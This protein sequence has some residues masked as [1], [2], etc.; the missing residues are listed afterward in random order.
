M[1]NEEPRIS[2]VDNEDASRDF[3]SP[4]REEADT[5]ASDAP[6]MEV[7]QATGNQQPPAGEPQLAP[8]ATEIVP[9]QN[10]VAHLAGNVSVDDIRV[11]GANLVL[12]QADGTEIVIVNGALHVPTFLIGDVALP[13]QAVIA[14][15]EQNHVN[16]AAGPDGSYSASA[17]PSSSGAEFEDGLN[18]PDDQPPTLAALLEDTQQ[19][20][21]LGAGPEDESFN[22]PPT[23]GALGPLVFQDT[24]NDDAFSTFV[25]QLPGS[26]IDSNNVLIYSVNGGQAL[27]GNAAYDVIKAGVYGTLYLNTATGA[28]SYVPNDGAI[29]ALKTGQSESFTFTVADKSGASASQTFTVNLNGVNDTAT[30]SGSATGAVVEDGKVEGEGKTEG[31]KLHAE[32]V[33]V[34]SDRDTQRWRQRA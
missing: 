18:Q 3:L 6:Q 8:H 12:V 10:N 9:D 32:G 31:D 30:I 25:G 29:E 13:Q 1:S 24:E 5:H 7:A 23:M 26:D 2:T 20:D 11:E 22:H 4:I 19:P 17:S 28:Y 16:V 21:G 33:V 34:V 27:A 14:A 15:L